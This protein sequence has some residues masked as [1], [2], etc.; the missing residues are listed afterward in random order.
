MSPFRRHLPV[1]AVLFAAAPTVAQNPLFDLTQAANQT[2]QNAA[3]AANQTAIQ[4]QQTVSQARQDAWAV[5]NNPAA[6]AQAALNPTTAAPTSTTSTSSTP[7]MVASTLPAAGPTAP[8]TNCSGTASPGQFR[9]CL[10][11][12]KHQT[13]SW[14]AQHPTVAQQKSDSN[15]PGYGVKPD[16]ITPPVRTQN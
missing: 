9:A 1:L 6:A 11:Q 12:T 4:T 15:G 8:T 14:K 5:R 7:S 2:A 10:Q 16:R 3:A 13:G